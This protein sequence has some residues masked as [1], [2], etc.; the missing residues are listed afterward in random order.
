VD[1]LCR[2]KLSISCGSSP[3]PVVY[4]HFLQANGM[5]IDEVEEFRYRGHGCPGDSPFA[6][7][8]DGREA[9]IDYVDFWY[10]REVESRK[11]AAREVAKAE[12]LASV[13]YDKSLDFNLM[14]QWRCKMC[15]DF[16][17]Y[18]AD[19]IVMGCWPNGPPEHREEVTTERK[20]EQD[21]WVLVIGRIDRG[22]A[23]LDAASGEA[24]LDAAS[25]AASGGV[26][27]ATPSA[28]SSQ[29]AH[30]PYLQ[31]QRPASVADVLNFSTPN[32]TRA[33][34]QSGSGRVD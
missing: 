32:L 29:L 16:L 23:L 14:Y 19:V 6:K 27:A 7:T 25:D 33:P 20:H 4:D 18:Q 2:Y 34:E 17:G 22:E 30:Q 5:Q 21:G 24:L 12:T 15:P 9:A 1:E 3:D 13:A 8:K 31:L 28:A 26:E 10:R 11:E